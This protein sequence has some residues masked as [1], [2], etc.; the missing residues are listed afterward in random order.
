MLY[1][2][3]T[4]E[5]T[6]LILI[7]PPSKHPVHRSH[8]LHLSLNLSPP[9]LC[10]LIPPVRPRQISLIQQA[11]PPVQ[12]SLLN[13]PR[14]HVIPPLFAHA[15]IVPLLS[16]PTI[17]AKRPL[18]VHRLK[19]L[20][21]EE[22]VRPGKYKHESKHEDHL[23]PLRQSPPIRPAVI[24]HLHAGI[25]HGEVNGE[26]PAVIRRAD[27]VLQ[28]TLDE[29][30]VPSRNPPLERKVLQP[31]WRLAVPLAP[32]FR[33]RRAFFRDTAGAAKPSGPGSEDGAST[34]FFKVSGSF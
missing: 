4:Y 32:I 10:L 1:K 20:C 11:L 14:P 21:A 5:R 27:H 6:S 31:G 29:I 23:N 17:P 2:K 33:G 12:H 18:Y 22:Q 19:L 25:P 30:K 24:V 3:R 28:F 16:V 8:S 13:R 9:L 15:N 7:R 26:F 34:D